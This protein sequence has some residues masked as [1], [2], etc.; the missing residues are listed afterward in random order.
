VSTDILTRF[1]AYMQARGLAAPTRK[2]YAYYIERCARESGRSLERLTPTQA[3]RW[4]ESLAVSNALSSSTF[5]LAHYSCRIWFCDF[6]GKSASF[7][8]KPASSRRRDAIT[9]LS[10]GQLLLLLDHLLDRR[11][12]LLALT[13]YAT[14]LRVG[15]GVS[16]RR[17][18]VL[19]EQGQIRVRRQ[20]GGG[21]RL[22]CLPPELARRL[23]QHCA[24]WQGSPFVF[25]SP[26]DP[27]HHLSVSTIQDAVR[28]ARRAARLPEWLTC[29]TLRH[30]FATHQLQLGLDVRSL[31][32]QMGHSSLA[33]TMRYLHALDLSHGRP[34]ATHDLCAVLT[35]VWR[36]Q[37]QRAN[38][39]V[40]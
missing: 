18:D 8:P 28:A 5:R 9:T 39:G 37:S 16:L 31:A 10:S 24:T 38:G 2:H 15:E 27:Q 14:G 29:H 11:D 36:R 26:E 17:D 32:Q 4:L 33:P 22:V 3:R 20:K 19:W 34:C 6:L 30:C 35:T 1:Q 23:R 12:R 25:A 7:G 40:R 13:L 21:G